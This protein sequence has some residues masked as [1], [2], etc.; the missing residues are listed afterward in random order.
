MATFNNFPWKYGKIC[1]KNPK[2]TYVTFAFD[3][4]FNHHNVK[5]TQ[6]KPL[7]MTL[8]NSQVPNS[9]FGTSKNTSMRQGTHL[10]FHSF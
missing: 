6:N 4:F 9:T 2:K 8:P 5:F 7:A 1:P 10:S 3:F